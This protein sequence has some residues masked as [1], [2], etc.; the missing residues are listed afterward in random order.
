[1]DKLV[2][3]VRDGPNVNKKIMKKMIEQTIKDEHPELKGK[4]NLGICDPSACRT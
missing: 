1:M 2:T 3:L 4:V